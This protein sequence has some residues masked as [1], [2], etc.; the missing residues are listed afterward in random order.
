V[1]G[2]W[3]GSAEDV[4]A[5]IQGAYREVKARGKPAALTLYYNQDC[6]ESK[7]TEMFTWAAANVPSDMKAGLDYV[8]ISYYEDDCN[9]FQPDW[10][11]VFQELAAI[12]PNS[13]IGIGECGT[14]VESSKAEVL[15]RTY[16]MEISNARFVGG[17]FWWY[18]SEDMVPRSQPLWS[19]LSQLLTSSSGQ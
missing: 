12:F 8:W 16:S 5:K 14:T 4:V 9:G 15:Q 7:S 6:W 13:R 19:T 17:F 2:E 10:A 11:S 3:L 1:N 18:F